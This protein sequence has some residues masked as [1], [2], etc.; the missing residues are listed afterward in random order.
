MERVTA[1]GICGSARKFSVRS[2][3]FKCHATEKE[4]EA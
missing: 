2:S 4:D 1:V 3:G